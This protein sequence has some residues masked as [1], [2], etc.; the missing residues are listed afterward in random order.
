ML[1]PVSQGRPLDQLKHQGPSAFCFFKTVDGGNAWMV[2]AGEHLRLSLEPCEAIRIGCEGF[3]QDLE[4]HL[5]VEFGIGGLVD[6]PH[7]PLADKG[8]DCVMPEPRAD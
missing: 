5:A 1:D 2:E 6:L 4:R 3:R 8:G 7:A